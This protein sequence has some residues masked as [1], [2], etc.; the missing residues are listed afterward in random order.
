MDRKS[1]YY[2]EVIRI[3][4]ERDLVGEYITP[5]GEF[6]FSGATLKFRKSEESEWRHLKDLDIELLQEICFFLQDNQ[7]IF[8][9]YEKVEERNKDEQRGDIELEEQEEIWVEGEYIGRVGIAK[10]EDKEMGE[11]VNRLLFISADYSWTTLTCYVGGQ[12][13][14]QKLAQKDLEGIISL[15]EKWRAKIASK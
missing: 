3:I 10:M 9:E 5:M 12:E 15:L 8:L 7:H 1:A 4:F 13:N 14:S 11:M 2:G 6:I